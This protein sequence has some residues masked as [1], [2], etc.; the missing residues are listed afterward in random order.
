MV[1]IGL[2]IGQKKLVYIILY[3][4]S[5]SNDVLLTVNRLNRYE[6]IN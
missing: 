5:K 4:Y 2:H 1:M 6:K 3:F